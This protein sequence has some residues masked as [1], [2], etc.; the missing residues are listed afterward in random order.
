MALGKSLDSA[1]SEDGLA[2]SDGG[3]KLFKMSASRRGS[4][5]EVDSIRGRRFRGSVVQEERPNLE[6]RRRFEGFSAKTL[7]ESVHGK[8]EGIDSMPSSRRSSRFL[9]WGGRGGDSSLDGSKSSP[10]RGVLQ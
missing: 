10:E 6:G 8:K 7:D 4:L 9:A 5:A 1:P 2:Y 3:G